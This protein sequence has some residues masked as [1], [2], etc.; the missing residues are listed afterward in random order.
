[1]PEILLLGKVPGN[2]PKPADMVGQREQS[3][4]HD[5]GIDQGQVIRADEPRPRM[6]FPECG[7][8]AA[9]LPDAPDPVAEEAHA[10][11]IQGTDNK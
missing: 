6:L 3:V 7:P 8:A 9:D 5:Q 10:E 11:E 4:R 2:G 1:M